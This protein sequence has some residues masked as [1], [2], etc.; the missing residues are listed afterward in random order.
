LPNG[1]VRWST[2]GNSYVQGPL[3]VG[4]VAG[5]AHTNQSTLTAKFIV[6]GIVKDSSGIPV[7][8]AAVLVGQEIAFTDSDGTFFVRLRKKNVVSI[9]VVPGDFRAPGKWHVISAPDLATPEPKDG[10]TVVNIEV[11][12]VV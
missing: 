2:Y 9:K 10:T 4:N 6:R 11:S 3:Q 12:R 7:A 5:Q 8:D 1:A